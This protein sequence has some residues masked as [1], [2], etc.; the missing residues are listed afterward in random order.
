[1]DE[2]Y[3]FR[4]CERLLGSEGELATRTIYFAEPS[5]LNDPMEGIREL[6]WQGDRIAWE[7]LFRHYLCCLNYMYIMIRLG[8]L[9]GPAVPADIPVNR[10]G[11]L[12][13][14]EEYAAQIDRI[15]GSVIT[16]HDNRSAV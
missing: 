5:K 1:M 12:M 13:A 15:W 11:E 8:G 14:T 6:V 16:A 9:G 7:N 4:T 3:R 2:V 10:A